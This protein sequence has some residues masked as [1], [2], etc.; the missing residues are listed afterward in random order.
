MGHGGQTWRGARRTGGDAVEEE[1]DVAED[2]GTVGRRRELEEELGE[3]IAFHG[4]GGSRGGRRGR[5]TADA[6]EGLHGGL[7][8]RRPCGS[9]KVKGRHEMGPAEGRRHGGAESS[10][11]R[12]WPREGEEGLSAVVRGGGRGDRGRGAALLSPCLSL[13]AHAQEGGR[14]RWGRW[15]SMQGG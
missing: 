1:A 5:S 8:G 12:R 13:T 4:G 10:G 6:L 11:R 2:G 3:A 14:D 7:H 15:G 9:R